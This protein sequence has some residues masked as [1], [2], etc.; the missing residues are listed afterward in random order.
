MAV[1]INGVSY[2]VTGISASAFKNCKNLRS[3]VI[4]KNVQVIA[5]NAFAGCSRLKKVTIKSVK[6]KKIGKNA[7]KDINKK[8]VIK[9]PKSKNKTYK[10]L[11]KKSGLK[12]TVRIKN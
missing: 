12:R 6:I 5:K 9:I 3:V 8:A 4:G 7:F 10:K 1:T 11:L 2:K